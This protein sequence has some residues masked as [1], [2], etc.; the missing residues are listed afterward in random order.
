ML[1][2]IA[3]ALIILF[4]TMALAEAA[5][6]VYNAFF[7]SF[8][9]ATGSYDRFRGEPHAEIFGFPLNSQGF[10]DAEFSASKPAGRY[11]IVALGD[12]FAFGAT[13]YPHNFLT[14]LEDGLR[15]SGR[16]M[17]VY[18]LGI[19]RT[20]LAQYL[21]VLENEG[22]RLNPDMVLVNLF[23][24]NDL[25]DYHPPE[26]RFLHSYLLDFL[27]YVAVVLPGVRESAPETAA[28]CDACPTL[29]DRNYLNW[30]RGRS[31]VFLKRYDRLEKVIAD[32]AGILKRIRDL[33]STR[34][35]PMAVA[36]LP[37]ELQVDPALLPR[38]L[39][40]YRDIGDMFGLERVGEADFDMEQPNRRLREE[41]RRLNI[42]HHDL[43]AEFRE[44][45][46]TEPLYKP[47]DTHWNIAGNR[48]AAQSI[49]KFVEG[50]TP[51]AKP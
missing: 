4:V 33:C 30:E 23:V 44:A 17:E 3:Q 50:L 22:L 10:N 20:D 11:R 27:K 1:K 28:Y 13:P 34:G 35:I 49:Q 36:L 14:L 19:A 2:S 16:D 51:G 5:F 18:N 7:P 29:S 40:D 12:S 26:A 43:L 38:L 8:I 31:I 15:R 6:R 37:G 47:N 42:P 25:T 21:E 41:L 9:F 39:E 46:K 32:A 48:L 24:G 45:A